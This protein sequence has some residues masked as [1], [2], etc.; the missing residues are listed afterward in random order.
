MPDSR[1]IRILVLR[2][3]VWRITHIHTCR[4]TFC[5]NTIDKKSLIYDVIRD[6]PKIF[7]Q[8]T[9]AMPFGKAL[10][11]SKKLSSKPAVKAADW[12]NF[13][14]LQLRVKFIPFK[15]YGSTSKTAVNSLAEWTPQQLISDILDPRTQA[16]LLS[17][18]KNSTF[19]QYST[20]IVQ[21]RDSRWYWHYPFTIFYKQHLKKSSLSI[22]SPSF[23][24]QRGLSS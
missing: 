11:F 9:G 16:R 18:A 21:T 10:L 1:R 4:T 6:H 7:S 17:R 22:H 13:L 14:R 24:L 19:I 12:T 23:K 3:I 15:W 5:N 20:I 8:C 2:E